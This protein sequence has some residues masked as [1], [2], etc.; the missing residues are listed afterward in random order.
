MESISRSPIY[1]HFGETVS[2]AST[3]RAYGMIKP[4]IQTNEDKID[5]NQ[6]QYLCQQTAEKYRTNKQY[7][8]NFTPY[9]MKKTIKIF[10]V[11]I[12]V[13]KIVLFLHF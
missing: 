13:K 4:F 7:R 9:Y 3:I 1:S 2:G 10:V 12:S 8:T 11:W 5:N 6:V